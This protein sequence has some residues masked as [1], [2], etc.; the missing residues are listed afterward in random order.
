MEIKIPSNVFT[1]SGQI[2]KT[3]AGDWVI[4]DGNVGLTCNVNKA[5][6]TTEFHAVD[7]NT[8]ET[9]L[10]IPDVPLMALTRAKRDQ[11]PPCRIQGISSEIL[12]RLGY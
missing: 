11:I 8:G 6:G 4:C 2:T 5:A 12:T 10:I 9:L 1:G 3:G 7:W